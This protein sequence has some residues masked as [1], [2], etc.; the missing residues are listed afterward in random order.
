MHS[1]GLHITRVSIALAFTVAIA[2]CNPFQTGT[3]EAP[4]GT[5]II[6]PQPTNPDNVLEIIALAMNAGDKPAYAERLATGFRFHPDPVQLDGNDFRN[7][8]TNWGVVEEEAYLAG[9]MSNTDS[10]NV[11]W[12][13]VLSQPGTTS[14]N[15][16]ALY[17]LT[18]HAGG[19]VE[20]FD[21]KAEF[22]M[23]ETA[24]ILYVSTWRD[25]VVGGNANTWGALR[26]QFLATG[27]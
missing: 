15:V 13:E 9:L 2:G 19:T 8:P 27:G 5:S 22:V 16:T 12:T 20:R 24:G 26:A 21:G 1:V 17:S 7:F 4:S 14:Y 18:F 23:I 6:Y 25:I 3:P 10:L 11:I